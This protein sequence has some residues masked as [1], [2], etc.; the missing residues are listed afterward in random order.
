ML[1][2]ALWIAGLV[3]V[4]W[5]AAR[6]GWR[7][8]AADV[9]W[10]VAPA[11]GLALGLVAANAL[12]YGVP[13]GLAAGLS[14]GLLALAV[15]VWWWRRR[16]GGTPDRAADEER[17][18]PVD[19]ADTL[20]WLV[21]GLAVTAAVGAGAF[22]TLLYDEELQHWPL[23][24]TIGEGNFPPRLPFW[25]DWPA[26]YHY[27]FALLAAAVHHLSGL[28]VWWSIDVLTLVVALAVF[29]G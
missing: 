7:L 21:A 14:T 18:A 26:V 1:V 16:R 15:I 5:A 24:A 17:S 9:V 2:V 10:G 13:A 28:A 29:W 22:A 3:L 12:A 4:G 23:A 6:W 11:V 20:I 27:G 8:G 25:P 19:A